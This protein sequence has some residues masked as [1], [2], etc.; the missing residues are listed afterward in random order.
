MQPTN[1][2][3]AK[4]CVVSKDVL[5]SSTAAPRIAAP[6]ASD[7][8]LLAADPGRTSVRNDLIIVFTITTSQFQ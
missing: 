3:K 2:N 4:F 1:Q 6:K 8:N 5:P 7:P